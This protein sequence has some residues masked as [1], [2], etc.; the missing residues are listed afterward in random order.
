MNFEKYVMDIIPCVVGPVCAVVAF[1][2]AVVGAGLVAVQVAAAST[3]VAAA[4]SRVELP[5]L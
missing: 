2:A 5:G 3:V 1:S 4:V